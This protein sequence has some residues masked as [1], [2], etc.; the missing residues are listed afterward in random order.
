[1][2][3]E[4]LIYEVKDQIAYITLNNPKR[5]LL[6]PPLCKALGKAWE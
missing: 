6:D 5:N 2:S 1:M 3:S 4:V